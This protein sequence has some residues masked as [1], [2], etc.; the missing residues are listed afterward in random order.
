MNNWIIAEKFA[1]KPYW[2]KHKFAPVWIL[3]NFGNRPLWPYEVYK[4]TKCGEYRK[5]TGR[6]FSKLDL[7]KDHA[8]TIINM[9]SA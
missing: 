6:T 3:K 5:A 9:E 8:E 4:T 2:Y 7:A 1:G